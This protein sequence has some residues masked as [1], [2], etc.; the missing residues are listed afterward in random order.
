MKKVIVTCDKCSKECD[1]RNFSAF[2]SP[3]VVL[4]EHKQMVQTFQEQNFCG[5]CTVKVKDAIAKL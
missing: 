3:Q 1:P 2:V 5:E 4:N